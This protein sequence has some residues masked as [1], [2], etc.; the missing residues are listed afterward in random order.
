[1]CDHSSSIFLHPFAPQVLP[2]FHATMDALT[3]ARLALRTLLKGNEHQPYSGQVS[4]VHVVRTS[5]H[6]VTKHLTCPA[7]AYSLPAQRDRLPGAALMGAPGHSR[8]GL[9]LGSAGS[10]HRTAESCSLPTDCMF[11]SGCSP[12]HLTATQLP[13]TTGSGHLP[14]GD[15]HPSVRARFQAHGPRLAPG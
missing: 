14:E 2:C 13:L 7:I 1:M 15:F 6:S 12:P 5:M 9:H 10:S 8:S 4:L 11:V 3:P